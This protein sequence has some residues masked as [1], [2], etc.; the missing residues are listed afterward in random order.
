V[1]QFGFRPAI[2][3]GPRYLCNPVNKLGPPPL[4]PS[5]PPIFPND[6]LACYEIDPFP[7]LADALV[8]D[9]I[10]PQPEFAM[11]DLSQ[12]LCVPS[13]KAL[14]PPP[15]RVIPTLSP[16]SQLALMAG[17]LGAG[18]GVWRWRGRRGAP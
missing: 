12:M 17:L 13:S 5:G 11:L 18:L 7:R 14:E 1:D 6:H 8:L 10:W 9:Q 16:W 2:V 3:L 4:E 15:E